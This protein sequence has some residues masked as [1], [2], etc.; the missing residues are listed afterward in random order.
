MSRQF[1][2]LILA[3]CMGMA[4]SAPAPAL[5]RGAVLYHS[6]RDGKMYGKEDALEL[7]CS[8][9]QLVLGEL[10]AGHVAL[11]VGDYKI[12]HAVLAGIEETVSTDFLPVKDQAKGME[13]L[14]AKVPVDYQ[15]PGIWPEE[16]KD[17][18]VLIAREQVGKGYDITFHRQ[19][20]P[21]SG[22]FTCVGFAEYVYEQMGYP[23]T[24]MG[25]YSGGDGGR[26]YTQL[27]NCISTLWF[28]WEGTN[29][30]ALEV[31]FS[32]FEHPLDWCCGREQD[33]GKHLFFPYTQFMQP[34]TVEVETDIPVTGGVNTK[35]G[36][37][38]QTLQ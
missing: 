32:R 4:A 37:F 14:G 24:P 35:G 10:G 34:T 17:Q 7:T 18:L 8:A 1:L 30:L 25:Y 26:T 23:L 6:G 15:D 3:V 5:E 27:Y 20:G 19:T 22:D 38:I 21:G 31:R 11:Y 29:T 33:G 36:C 12:I 2:C 28:D 16:R 13:Y 9:L